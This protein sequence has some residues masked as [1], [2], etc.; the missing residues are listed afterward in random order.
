MVMGPV[1]KTLK[2]QTLQNRLNI[3]IGL[4][5]LV[6]LFGLVNFWFGMRVMSG[7]R[8]Y[9]G[10]E[11]L[12]SKAQKEAVSHLVRYSG[13]HDE[14]D[15]QKFREFAQVQ[16]GDKQARL[17]LD[18]PKPNRAVISDGF[19][20]GGNH[21]DDVDDMIFL[22]RRFKNVSYM[23]SAIRTWSEGDREIENLLSAGERIRE[24]ITTTPA[25]DE[26]A[27]TSLNIQL[28]SQVKQV[29]DIDTRL[30]VLENRFSATL[31]EGAR[32][33]TSTLLRLTIGITCLLGVLSLTVAL[34]ITRAIVRLDRLKTEFVSLASHQLRTP[35]T[36][37][38]WSSEA[39]LSPRLS[40]T[41]NPIQKKYVRELYTGGQRMANLIRDLLSVSS[42][43]LGTYKL[44]EI[45]VNIGEILDA[46]LK[47][48]Q[49][50]IKQKDITVNTTIDPQIPVL[51]LD[52]QLL[53]VV[54]Q[55]L[56]SN[57]VKYTPKGGQVTIDISLR[58]NHVFITVADTGI[59]IP[60]DEQ[61]QIFTKIFR[62]RNAKD[63]SSNEGTGL[64]LYIAKA[65]AQ[66]LGGSIQF[67]SVENKGSIFYVKLPL[68]RGSHAK[69]NGQDRS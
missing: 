18:K 16:L 44:E 49:K 62:A 37:M 33:I 31:N 32:G 50:V 27:R 30:T 20:R 43:D 10:G 5:I 66:R 9:V 40:G 12:W 63:F 11:G 23:S 8:A 42:L 35:L 46:I 34:M 39:L 64:G 17:E 47:D 45:D 25:T 14:S 15:Y 28:A 4:V 1:V 24:L 61:P 55:N 19:I 48:E 57:S 6:L 21:P 7:I 22:Y 26:T 65:M 36:A 29:Y 38:N 67:D 54:L 53:T 60:P 13:S 3:I 2:R 41:L 68:N 52:K 69:Q 59:G 51:R 58:K 56:V